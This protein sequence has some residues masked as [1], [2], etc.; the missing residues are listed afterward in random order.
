MSEQPESTGVRRREFLKILGA[1]GAATATLG[2]G[3]GEVERLIPYLIHP[4]QTVPGVSSYYATTCRE[5]SSACGVIAEVRDGRTI[6]L[7]GNPDHPLNRGALCA[8]GQA[9]L[10][11]LYNPDRYRGP[12]VRQGGRLVPT[13]WDQAMQLLVQRIGE[14]RAGGRAANALFLNRH[15]TGSFAAFLDSWLSAMGMPPA[16]SLDVLAQTAVMEAN[17]QSYGVAWPS[18]DFGAARL[19]VSFGADFLD[20]WGATIPQQLD[21]ADARAKL[22]TAP[23]MIYIGPRRSLTGLNADEWIA[24]KPGAELAIARA[25]QSGAKG[26][27]GGGDNASVEQAAQLSGVPAAQLQRLAAEIAAS[28]PSLLLA[29]ARTANASELAL[30]INALN[31]SLGN[32]GATVKPTSPITSFDGTTPAAEL[33]ATVQRMRSG[34]VPI[35]FVRGVNP[36]FTIPRAVDFAGAF[37]RVPF[38]VAFSSYPDETSEMCDLVLPDHH[39]LESWGDATPVPG[40]IGLQQ[41]T[42]E[43]VFNTRQTADVLLLAARSGGVSVGAGA[44][45]TWRDLFISRIPGGAAALTAALPRGLMP[46]SL[47]GAP[48]RRPAVAPAPTPSPLPPP[49]ESAPGDFYLVVYPS[50][51]LGDGSGA[52]KPWLQELPDP[53]TKIA[54]QTWVEVH[55]LTAARLGIESGDLIRVSGPGGKAVEVPAYVYLGIRQDT[56]AM[57]FGRGHSAYGRYAKDVGVNPLD[58]FASGTDAR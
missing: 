34:Q 16:L 9:A 22:A 57:A 38:K 3:T 13:T 5:C 20:D 19:I 1:T 40:T 12:M 10:Q 23:R 44:T 42:M 33:L 53:V 55:P 26:G 47:Q 8:R 45:T 28:K 32:V 17:R 54:W 11:G 25:L 14:A 31:Q 18:L 6:K 24:C 37:A 50:S 35:A 41:P 48:S 15:E 7:E 52:N 58:L 49:T 56:V 30:T 4:D 2:C 27:G 29:G 21:F 43:P 51:V 39:P 46:G 36:A